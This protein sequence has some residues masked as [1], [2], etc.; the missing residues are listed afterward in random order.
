MLCGKWRSLMT[1]LPR[2]RG[3]RQPHAGRKQSPRVSPPSLSMQEIAA[4]KVT[5]N[6]PYNE[7]CQLQIAGRGLSGQR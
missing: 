4:L 5:L 2:P 3:L 6:S 7:D 1:Q